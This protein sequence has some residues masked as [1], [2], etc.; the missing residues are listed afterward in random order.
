LIKAG[1]VGRS[2]AEVEVEEDDTG[3]GTLHS[4]EANDHPSSGVT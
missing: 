2:K 3:K 1:K 4:K